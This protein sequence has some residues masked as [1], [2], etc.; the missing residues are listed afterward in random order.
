MQAKLPLNKVLLPG[1]LYLSYN[2]L[3]Q[4]ASALTLGSM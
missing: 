1:F 4:A 3:I 2:V